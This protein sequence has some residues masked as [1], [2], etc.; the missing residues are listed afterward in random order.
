MFLAY[1]LCER[2]LLIKI[3]KNNYLSV[4][5]NYVIQHNYMVKN[6]YTES[7]TYLRRRLLFKECFLILISLLLKSTKPR[8]YN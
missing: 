2:K 6:L 4:L 1:L 5:H 7:Y 3:L 8:P